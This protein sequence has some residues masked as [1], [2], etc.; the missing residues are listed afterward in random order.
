M[1]PHADSRG[2][3]RHRQHLQLPQTHLPLHRQLPPGAPAD[4]AGEDAAGHPQIPLYL[5]SGETK[6][7]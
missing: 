4:L 3:V 6:M 1:A 5:L 2:A 7:Y